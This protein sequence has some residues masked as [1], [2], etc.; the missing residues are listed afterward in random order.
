MVVSSEADVKKWPH[1][2]VTGA[3]GWLYYN[4]QTDAASWGN[5]VIDSAELSPEGKRWCEY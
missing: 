2:G 1:L 5:V 4:N 3:G